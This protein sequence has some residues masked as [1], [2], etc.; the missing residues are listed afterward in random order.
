MNNKSI[1]Y[2]LLSVAITSS[3]LFT[4]CG[5]EHTF[6]E[7]TCTTPKTCTE[8]NEIEGEALGHNWV[9][10][11]CDNP[12]TCSVCNLTEGETLE[13]SWIEATTEAPKTCDLCGLTEGDPLVDSTGSDVT[14]DEG[15]YVEPTMEEIGA[16]QT[17]DISEID[18]AME[19]AKQDM[20]KFLE[21]GIISQEDY[22]AAMETLNKGPQIGNNN[23]QTKPSQSAAE[24]AIAKQY[25]EN[26]AKAR[27]EMSTNGTGDKRTNI[28]YSNVDGKGLEGYRI[29]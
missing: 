19:Q 23:T 3:L 26:A 20:K 16:E 10:A 9:E 15:D 17:T 1:K 24:E 27:A 8:C 12:K 29:N 2:I 25:E 21:A 7:A 13:H 28:D 18:E 14:I 4:A 6:S 22:D 5:H 11:S